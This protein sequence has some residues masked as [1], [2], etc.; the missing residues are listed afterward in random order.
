[1][2]NF[3]VFAWGVGVGVCPGVGVTPGV[4]V[5]PGVGVGS[6]PPLPQAG[7][8]IRISAT[9]NARMPTISFP[10]IFVSSSTTL[11]IAAANSVIATY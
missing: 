2:P 6:A 8:N 7:A 4:G 3:I 11:G 9:T 5:I 10:L 1:M